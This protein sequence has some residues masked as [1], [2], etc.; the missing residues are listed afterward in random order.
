[1]VH[2]EKWL[3]QGY[4]GR[5]QQPT[6]QQHFR[7]ILRHLWGR[8]MLFSTVRCGDINVSYGFAILADGWIQ[9][10]R[11]AYRSEFHNYSPGKIHVAMLIEEAC[12]QGWKGFDF[13]LGEEPYKMEW[14]NDTLEVVNIHAGFNEWAPSYFW[15][16]RGK[17]YVRRGLAAHYMRA[18]A[19]LQKRRLAQEPRAGDKRDSS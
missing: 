13:L 18:Q 8:G 19:W 15:F 11:P 17:P 5:F 7:A 2:D 4:P 3:A 10:M 12:S 9:W 16:S 14:S 6:E 1:M